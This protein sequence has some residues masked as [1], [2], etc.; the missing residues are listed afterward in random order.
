MK[1]LSG[2]DGA[3]LHLE[4]GQTP[5]HVA[6]LHLFDLPAGVSGADFHAAI[7]RQM[8]RRIHLAPV[9]ER[10]LAPMPLQFANPAW[11]RDAAVD[12]DHHVQRVTLPAPGGLAEFEA[13]AA[14][15]HA[16]LLDRHRPL[17]R[18]TVIDGLASGQAG[19]YVKVHHAAVDGQAGVLL[20]RALFDLEPKPRA[21]PRA[22]PVRPEHPG[23]AELA[24]AA[25]RHDAAQ[26]V[27]LVRHLPDVVRTLAGLFT[28][29]GAG[30]PRTGM[31]Q[32]LAF[33]PHTPLNVQ[34]T[35]ERCFAGAALPLDALKRLAAAHGAKVNDIVLA[36]A[37]GALRRWLAAHGGIPRRPLIAAI[38][39]SLRAADDTEFSTQATMT[40]VNLH[41]HVADP[42]RRLAAIRDAAG[43]AKALTGRAKSVLP[44]D[45]PSIAVPWVLHG[46][47]SMYGRSGLA[48]AIPPIANLVIS[49][50]PGPQ[51]PLFAA[52][53]RMRTYWPLSIPEHGLG[54]NLTVLSYDGTMYFGFVAARNAVPEARALAVALQAAC[55]ELVAKTRPA[56]PTAR[57]AA[58]GPAR[59]A[60]HGARR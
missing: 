54:L 43:A 48:G 22:G 60:E 6:S 51:V 58:P 52:G 2:L 37:S 26:Y 19:Y 55:D 35:G 3:F 5:M 40:L 30:A 56:P 1:P 23:M 7:Q 20:A 16:E 14:R 38:P 42:L 39:V 29:A 36:L 57:R 31:G 25:L 8:R 11:V 41:T 50:V 28:S 49:N 46:L 12:L 9:F 24:A 18:L 10:K 15:L 59:R 17:W 27:K 45:F 4:T 44:T 32:N 47:A 33:G 53:A 34:I 13:C 21:L